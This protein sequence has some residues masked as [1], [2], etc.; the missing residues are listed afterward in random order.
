MSKAY[1]RGSFWPVRRR[2][3][4]PP[5]TDAD[6]LAIARF[7]ARYFLDHAMIIPAWHHAVWSHDEVVFWL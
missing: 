4:E 1:V 5:I 6:V 7:N 3:G 2:Q